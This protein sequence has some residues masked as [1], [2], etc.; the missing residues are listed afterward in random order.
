VSQ[1]QPILSSAEKKL[2]QDMKE[3]KE[4]LREFQ[5]ALEQVKTKQNYHRVQVCF[6]EF[7]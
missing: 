2:L 5:K 6:K 3:F 4:K 7:Y 1:R